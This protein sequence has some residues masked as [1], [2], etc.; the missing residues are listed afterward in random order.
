[1][2]QPVDNGWI[3]AAGSTGGVGT[4]PVDAT[5]RTTPTFPP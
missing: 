2:L 1:M 4:E 3:T 5:R